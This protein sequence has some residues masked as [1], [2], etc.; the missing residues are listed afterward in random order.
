MAAER[1]TGS[2]GWAAV[3][4]AMAVLG[5][6]LVPTAATAKSDRF[7]GVVPQSPLSDDD[8]PAMRAGGVGSVRLL[9][10]WAA[11]E[12][13]RGEFD[14][15]SVDRE[16]SVL[17]DAGVEPMPFLYGTPAWLESQ[18]RRPPLRN[19]AARRAWKR[20][21]RKVVR[22]YGREGTFT[23]RE[24]G[25]A[26]RQWQVWNEP[27]LYGFWRPKPNPRA[28]GKLLQIS[29]EA[30]RGEDRGA[31]I[32]AAGLPPAQ[33]G[34]QPGDYL[35]RLLAVRGIER[36]F[37]L[38]AVHPYSE[39]VKGMLGIVRQ[40]RGIL[41]RKGLEDKGL[42]VT[43]FGW[44][45]AGYP[46]TEIQTPSGQ[47]KILGEAYDALL[48]RR[49]RWSIRRVFWFAWKDRP[50]AHMACPFC[51]TAGLLSVDDEGKPA[52]YVYRSR[53]RGTPH[54]QDP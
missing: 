26:V 43:E 19:P 5:S 49:D 7:Y 2:K 35:K 31:K 17:A 3:V 25:P 53:A 30:I 48:E 47:A 1:S 20:F 50:D 46:N 15:S 32:V 4:L 14:F 38:A 54:G 12:R 52:W 6:L 22:R 29:A 42:M 37:D 10:N 13:T 41:D 39:D 27:N 28:Y 9:F 33:R 16:L 8:A 24:D 36:Y 40:L 34:I 23:K 45:S 44:G 51:P 11:I 21:V 18:A